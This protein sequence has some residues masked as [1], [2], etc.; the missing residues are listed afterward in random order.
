MKQ[1][2]YATFSIIKSEGK[3]NKTFHFLFYGFDW[4]DGNIEK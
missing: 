4:V 1:F 3:I 2:C